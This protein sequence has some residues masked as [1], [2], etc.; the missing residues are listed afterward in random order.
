M[1]DPD[2]ET[3][4]NA[5]RNGQSLPGP[6]NGM[7]HT[8]EAWNSGKYVRDHMQAASQIWQQVEQH[9]SRPPPSG[10]RGTSRAELTPWK[11]WCLLGFSVVGAFIL[12]AKVYHASDDVVWALLCAMGGG[13][14]GLL[15]AVVF[16]VCIEMIGALLRRPAVLALV[17]IA[18]AYAGHQYWHLF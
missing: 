17:L 5:G 13:I 6:L 7:E 18:G 9:N 10:F 1:S 14:A 15:A 4:F 8:D 3:R 11:N 2:Y 16:V 12:G